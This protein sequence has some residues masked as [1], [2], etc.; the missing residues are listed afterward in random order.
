MSKCEI[1]VLRCLDLQKKSSNQAK[2]AED[3]KIVKRKK[4]T[5]T[6]CPYYKQTAVEELRNYALTEILDIEDLVTGGKELKAC[7]YYASRK[8]AEDAEI[9]LIPY[10]TLLHKATREANG[11][12]LK[13]NVIIIDE[14]HNLLEALA[15]MYSHELAYNQVYH[16]LLQLKA[17][18]HKFNTRFSAKTLLLLNQM[19]YVVSQLYQI[20][21]KIFFHINKLH[22]K[23][24]KQFIYICTHYDIQLT[25]PHNFYLYANFNCY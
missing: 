16:S 6:S 8:A 19:I 22:I 11:I 17:Y 21:G 1:I 20:L 23:K 12:Q 18:K 9:V 5:E 25:K 3:G 10:N 7:P 15:Q 14:A 2:V 13:H 24:K 4:G